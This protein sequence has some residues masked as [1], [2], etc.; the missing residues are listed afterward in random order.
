MLYDYLEK[1]TTADGSGH[2]KRAA[3]QNARFCPQQAAPAEAAWKLVRFL[4]PA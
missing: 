1:K 3:S 4:S 2:A